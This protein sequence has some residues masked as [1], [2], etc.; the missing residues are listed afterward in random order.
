M[1]STDLL[2]MTAIMI[3]AAGST[4]DSTFASISKSVGQDLPGIAGKTLKRPVRVGLWA[5]VMLAIFGN[6]PMVAGTDILKATTVSGTMVMGLAPVFLLAPLVRQPSPWSF[7]LAFWP[8]VALGVALAASA[9]PASWAIGT[10][11]YALL[12]GVNLYGLT[13]CFVGFLWPL[14]WRKFRAARP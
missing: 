12:L 1:C 8:G 3:L 14:A 4:V 7:H 11:K 6:F 13:L 10:G 5:M 2:L 9:I